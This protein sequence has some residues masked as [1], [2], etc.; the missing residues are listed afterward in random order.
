[1]HKLAAVLIVLLAVGLIAHA[2]ETPKIEVFTGYSFVSAGSPSLPIQ[3][4]AMGTG[5]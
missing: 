5:S 4:Q 1:M 3:L 2:Q